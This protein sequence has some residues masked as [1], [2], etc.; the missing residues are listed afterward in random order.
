MLLFR[1]EV[2]IGVVESASFR[3]RGQNWWYRRWGISYDVDGYITC[4]MICHPSLYYLCVT[5]QFIIFYLIA[6]VSLL[7][8]YKY[9]Y[10]LCDRPLDHAPVCCVCP[11]LRFLLFCSCDPLSLSLC[12]PPAKNDAC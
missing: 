1:G 5:K 7:C 12:F 9:S 6:P 11:V 2:V 8:R 3:L 4:G 10:S